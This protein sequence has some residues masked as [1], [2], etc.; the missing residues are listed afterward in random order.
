MRWGVGVRFGGN[1]KTYH[2]DARCVSLQVGEEC[3]VETSLGLELG[4]VVKGPFVINDTDD[5]KTVIRKADEI[6]RI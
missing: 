6:D 5:L 1:P 2:F 3:V 4:K